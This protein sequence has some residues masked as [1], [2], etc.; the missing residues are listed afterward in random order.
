MN[1]GIPL[2]SSKKERAQAP[3]RSES[4]AKLRHKLLK[5]QKSVVD[6]SLCFTPAVFLKL[7]PLKKKRMWD[8]SR[9]KSYQKWVHEHRCLFCK[10][11]RNETVDV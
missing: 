8:K 10:Q 3:I 6:R 5:L 7:E 4:T 2:T 9:K 11:S 1:M